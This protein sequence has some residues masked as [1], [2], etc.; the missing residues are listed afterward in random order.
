MEGRGGGLV[1]LRAEKASYRAQSAARRTEERETHH[2]VSQKRRR[3]EA[4]A[5]HK[6]DRK[7]RIGRQTAAITPRQP[8]VPPHLFISIPFLH[9]PAHPF[10]A[11]KRLGVVL[12]SL[13][14]FNSSLLWTKP[15]LAHS[16]SKHRRHERRL[17]HQRSPTGTPC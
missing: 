6:H 5:G 1:F 10:R 7:R 15:R 13:S 2:G 14:L 16:V 3:E 8:R 9:R 17:W 4:I 12:F 11:R